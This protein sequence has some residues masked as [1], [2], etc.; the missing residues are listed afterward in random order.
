MKRVY[1]ADIFMKWFLSSH[2]VWRVVLVYRV[3]PDEMVEMDRKVLKAYKDNQDQKDHGGTR[4]PKENEV[5]WDSRDLL[6]KR[7]KLVLGDSRVH[8]DLVLKETREHLDR[9]D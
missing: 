4:D 2:H 6:A 8:P 9:E 5:P 7:V 3:R 1:I